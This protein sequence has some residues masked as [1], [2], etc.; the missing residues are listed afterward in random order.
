MLLSLLFI[1]PST[2]IYF[3]FYFA[4]FIIH[5]YLLLRWL[6][7]SIS[8]RYFSCFAMAFSCCQVPFVRCVGKILTWYLFGRNRRI[9][10][11]EQ[12]NHVIKHVCDR[13]LAVRVESRR[14]KVNIFYT[15]YACI[16][17]LLQEKMYGLL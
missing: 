6:F 14:K 5:F 15:N 3:F 12:R 13:K 17:L 8:T 10:L 1:I 4:A 16:S 9:Q 7:S 11:L 2:C